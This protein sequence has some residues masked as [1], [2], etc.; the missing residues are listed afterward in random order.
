MQ[1]T[2]RQKTSHLA[3]V[4]ITLIANISI[5]QAGIAEDASEYDDSY[6]SSIT[7]RKFGENPQIRGYYLICSKDLV[8]THGDPSRLDG[9]DFNS[10]SDA[11]KYLSAALL[12]VDKS[13]RDHWKKKEFK[14]DKRFHSY[15]ATLLIG[16]VKY[17]DFH[18]NFRREKWHLVSERYKRY[19]FDPKKSYRLA[20]KGGDVYA[21]AAKNETT[22]KRLI[23]YDFKN[24]EGKQISLEFPL[25]YTGVY[26]H[27][28]S[29]TDLN[30]N[31]LKIH[32]KDYHRDYNKGK[33]NSA[34]YCDND[35][36]LFHQ[37]S[38]I[39]LEPERRK[40]DGTSERLPVLILI[41]DKYL[42]GG[43]PIPSDSRVSF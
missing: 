6:F 14:L 13:N 16:S 24:N 41:T 33:I 21:R 28:F 10:K 20:A 36:G 1:K 29:L 32:E 40:T 38:V 43:N 31:V 22:S 34:V 18:E 8:I 15:E 35:R 17:N 11:T 39:I 9:K 30:N 7:Q 27:Y 12:P 2:R 5:C 26:G 37:R 4:A 42:R 23:V 3:A 19:E 25:E